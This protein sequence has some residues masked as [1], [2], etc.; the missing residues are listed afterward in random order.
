MTDFF[1]REPS[2]GDGTARPT[3]DG[4]LRS[5]AT[6]TTRRSQ[7]LLYTGFYHDPSSCL[8]VPASPRFNGLRIVHP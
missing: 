2:H 5:P 8:T 1:I 4:E 7:A 3:R 6:V